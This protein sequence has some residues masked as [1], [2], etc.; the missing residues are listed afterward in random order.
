[1]SEVIGHKDDLRKNSQT[2]LWIRLSQCFRSRLRKGGTEPTRA[3]TSEVESDCSHCLVFWF[4]AT[5]QLIC[6]GNLLE[7][8]KQL[9]IPG[10]EDH[11]AHVET[12]VK[13]PLSHPSLGNWLL[14]L[15]NVD[16]RH[17]RYR[18]VHQYGSGVGAEIPRAG[19]GF[20]D[21]VIELLSEDFED[22]S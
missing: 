15:A 22:E 7:T 6:E 16:A 5:T 3:L 1:M 8:G 9:Y 4:Q 21:E 2:L 12:L 19:P 17:Y 10:I 20:E 14:V 18:F 13:Q 11:T